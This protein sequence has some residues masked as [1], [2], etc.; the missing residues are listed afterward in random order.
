M[1]EVRCSSMEVVE[2]LLE[3]EEMCNSMVEEVIS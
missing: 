1:G 2:T 3:V